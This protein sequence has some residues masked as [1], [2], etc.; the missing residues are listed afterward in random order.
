M[1]ALLVGEMSP[2]P[3]G[4][5][6]SLFI[7][8]L[9]LPHLFSTIHLLN[10]TLVGDNILQVLSIPTWHIVTAIFLNSGQLLKK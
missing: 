10:N 1:N 6:T 9:I 7:N 8:N 2:G 4:C 3:T 5:V